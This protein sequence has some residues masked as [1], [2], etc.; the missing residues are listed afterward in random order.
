MVTDVD[1]ATRIMTYAL[2]GEEGTPQ[3]DGAGAAAA[4]MPL[5]RP[6]TPA[7][8]NGAWTGDAEGG[9]GAGPGA[10]GHVGDDAGDDDGGGNRSRGSGGGL[11]SRPTARRD[12][13]NGD[14][15]EGGSSAAPR[16]GVRGGDA[17]DSSAFAAA[18]AMDGLTDEAVVAAFSAGG[19]AAGTTVDVDGKEHLAVRRALTTLAKSR[20]GEVPL[21]AELAAAI[22]REAA[23]TRLLSDSDVL[24]RWLA[25]QLHALV[26][27]GKVVVA[28][29]T[30]VL[31]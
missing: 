15:D 30:V 18:A 12:D 25:A 17:G 4:A 24:L 13:G 29:G 2:Y 16:G 26:N 19:P 6:L 23:P 5:A 10:G 9:G 22:V 28:G 3:G 8:T 21:G 31:V 1:V 20:G 7:R 11:G 14:E 27:D